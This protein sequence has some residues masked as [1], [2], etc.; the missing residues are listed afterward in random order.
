MKKFL[1][2]RLEIIAAN[3]K[4][5]RLERNYSQEYLAGKMKIAATEYNELE[6]GHTELTL[7]KLLRIAEILNISILELIEHDPTHI[8]SHDPNDKPG[9]Q[10]A[11]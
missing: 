2:S 5:T 4:S 1:N 7:D 8:T 6:T 3:I 11:Q 9:Q 10:V